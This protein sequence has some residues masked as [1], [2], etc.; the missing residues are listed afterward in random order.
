MSQNRNFERKSQK[1]KA[2]ESFRHHGQNDRSEK[3]TQEY[4]DKQVHNEED[5]EAELIEND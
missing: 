1:T 2:S 4:T 3:E 5:R